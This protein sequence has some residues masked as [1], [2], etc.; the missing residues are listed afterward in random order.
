MRKLLF[1]AEKGAVMVN[2]VSQPEL[3]GMSFGPYLK[4]LRRQ[5]NISV[6]S[7]AAEIKISPAQVAWIEAE[8]HERLPADVYVKGILKSYARFI[9]VDE[10]DI[11]DRYMICRGC[12]GAAV[13]GLPVKESTERNFKPQAWLFFQILTILMVISVLYMIHQAS[14]RP[15]STMAENR[16]RDVQAVHAGKAG[17]PTAK[18][19][20]VSRLEVNARE[21]TRLRVRVD[22]GEPTEWML[23]PMD[24]IELAVSR[25]VR[26]EMD[27]ANGLRIR[28]N[29]EMIAVPG[30][31]GEAAILEL[32]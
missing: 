30:K 10:T 31:S 15:S 11:I 18:R 12:C 4:D 6:E 32:P 26:L 13:R 2:A 27:N 25:R 17:P 19:Q 22:A 1:F 14:L 8:D 16:V 5:K 21:K 29:G 7:V 3:A 28:W 23:F 20:A 24:H 9:G